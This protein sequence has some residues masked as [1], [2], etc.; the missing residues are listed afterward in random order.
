VIHRLDASGPGLAFHVAL[1]RPGVGPVRYELVASGAAVGPGFVVV[2]AD[3]IA[4]P[5]HGR[6]EFRAE[7]LWTELIEE[8]RGRRWTLGLE[9]FG[10][11]VDGPADAVGDR[12]AVGYDLDYEDGV[13]RGDLL[14]GTAVVAVE[15]A[16][17]FT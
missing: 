2:R 16:A 1:D 13:V 6:W 11:R 4:R 10:L 12:V 9:A 17:T 7:G 14:V 15:L 5:A 8:E 3:D